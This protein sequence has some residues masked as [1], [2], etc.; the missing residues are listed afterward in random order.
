MYILAVKSSLKHRLRLEESI[1]EVLLLSRAL[2]AWL[3]V[4]RES[5]F[6]L[7][8]FDRVRRIVVLF[9][10]LDRE[11]WSKWPFRSKFIL[12]PTGS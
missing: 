11:I 5:H 8:F 6:E 10:E 2:S 9:N 7:K 4:A 1:V 3:I 12:S